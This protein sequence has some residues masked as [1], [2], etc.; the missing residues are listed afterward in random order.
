V[1]E[2]VLI[3]RSG[4]SG[5]AIASWEKEIAF[6]EVFSTN[7]R[8]DADIKLISSLNRLHATSRYVATP[9]SRVR[10]YCLLTVEGG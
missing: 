2:G 10:I 1:E 6:S 9:A 8:H 3:P 7:A 5:K 4:V